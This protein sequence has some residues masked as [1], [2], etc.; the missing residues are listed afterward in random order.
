MD[1]HKFREKVNSW[2]S[3]LEDTTAKTSD[4]QLT[5]WNL[6]FT[7]EEQEDSVPVS[8]LFGEDVTTVSGQYDA[9]MLD[10]ARSQLA[11]RLGI[12]SRWIQDPEKCPVELREKVFNWKFFNEEEKDLFLRL[13]G[14][15]LRAVLS[16]KYTQFDHADLFGA[17]FNALEMN[18]MLPHVNVLKSHLGDTMAAYLVWKGTDFS[19]NGNDRPLGDGGGTGG[20]KPAVYI[21][22]SEIGTGSSRIH[23]GLYRSFCDNGMILGWKA[24]TAFQIIHRFKN[25]NQIALLAN[26]AIAEALKLSEAAA[27]KFIEA[28]HQFIA[29]TS[30]K[31]ITGKWAK[32]Y[33]LTVG[34]NE[35]WL[36]AVTSGSKQTGRVSY[37][38]LIN[39]AT[40]Y[41][42][43]TEDSDLVQTFERM[44]GEMVFAEVPRDAVLDNRL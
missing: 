21:S 42:H 1:I 16:E 7:P 19:G 36:E 14:G 29:P 10:H 22:N 17:V 24:D 37:A 13:K 3:D 20:L 39:Q 11:G 9:P 5:E 30:L 25:R 12:P 18:E 33:G 34:Q 27:Q 8:A 2:N 32:K 44:A 26:E 38:D 15:N 35:S 28:Q 31:S 40:Y 43:R 4:M 23:G 41:A 6:E